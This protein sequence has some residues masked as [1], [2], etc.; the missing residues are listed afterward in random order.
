[1]TGELNG[2]KTSMMLD[3]GA[4]MSVFPKSFRSGH[5]TMYHTTMGLVEETFVLQCVLVRL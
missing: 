2:M 3:S 5:R 4:D 1:M